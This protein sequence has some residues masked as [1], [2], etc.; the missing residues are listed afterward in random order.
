[1]KFCNFLRISFFIPNYFKINFLP[2]LKHFLNWN[3]M[4]NCLIISLWT[5]K[6]GHTVYMEKL[7]YFISNQKQ[8]IYKAFYF[9][10]ANYWST[11]PIA[12]LI[13]LRDLC[14]FCIYKSWI[15]FYFPESGLET[16]YNSFYLFFFFFWKIRK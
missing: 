10:V 11:F 14:F 1:M 9:I 2:Y 6:S 12:F 4:I 13:Y 5:F 16:E 8:T 7:K 15:N 3:Y